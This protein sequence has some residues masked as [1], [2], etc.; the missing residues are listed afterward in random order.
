M[1]AY[2]VSRQ[3]LDAAQLRNFLSE[4][5]IAETIPNFFVHLNKFR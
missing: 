1:V 4:L 5:L 2:Y 3:E